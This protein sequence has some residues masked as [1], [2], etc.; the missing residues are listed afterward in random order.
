MLLPGREGGR[1]KAGWLQVAP[2]WCCAP[3]MCVSQGLYRVVMLLEIPPVPRVTITYTVLIP[4]SGRMLGGHTSA[5][6]PLLSMP[7]GS[8]PGV[9]EPGQGLWNELR[10]Q[11]NV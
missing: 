9:S 11:R 10:L 2:A 4:V 1:R 3:A 5:Q 8:K 7:L 6:A